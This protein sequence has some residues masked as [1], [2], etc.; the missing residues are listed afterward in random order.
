MENVVKGILDIVQTEGFDWSP[1]APR[2][3]CSVDED[4][5]PPH[6]ALVDRF[7]RAD[8]AGPDNGGVI[9]L[10]MQALR[11]PILVALETG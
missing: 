11:T 8:Y 2:L 3:C 6:P 7:E 5:L 10:S 9:H 4:N 1:G